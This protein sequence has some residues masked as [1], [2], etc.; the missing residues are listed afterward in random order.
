MIVWITGSSASGKSTINY[1]VI[2]NLGVGY[3]NKKHSVPFYSF[4]DII[5]IG[6]YVAPGR[7]LNGT[8]GIMVGKD[9]LKKFID[10][11]YSNWR[12]ILMEGVKFVNEEMFN[13]LT[14]YDLK[15]FYMNPPMNL[16]LERSKKRGS[17]WDKKITLQKRQSEREKYN[18]LI[19]NLKYKKYIEIRENLNMEESNNISK[20]ILDILNP[21]RNGMLPI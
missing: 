2:E 9:K 5:A 21:T 8:D 3:K 14:Q 13:H 16:I 17:G 7:Q 19:N 12:H 10:I 18:K 15:I 11:E 1:K 4:D 6:R 20:E